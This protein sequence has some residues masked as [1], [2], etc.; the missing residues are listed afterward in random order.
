MDLKI[1]QIFLLS[2]V[3]IAST[4]FSIEAYSQ[5]KP[6]VD[7]FTYLKSG[8][9]KSIVLGQK[10]N[11]NYAL[12][13]LGYESDSLLFM[14]MKVVQAHEFKVKENKPLLLKFENDSITSIPAEKQVD[15]IRHKILIFD[16]QYGDI[17]YKMDMK[18][19]ELMAVQ[20]LTHMRVVTDSVPITI[21]VSEE[22]AEKM[23]YQ[24]RALLEQMQ[25]LGFY[26][27]NFEIQNLEP[28]IVELESK[29]K[30]LIKKG[31]SMGSAGKQYKK[32]GK[33]L[34]KESKRKGKEKKRELKKQKKA[35]K[36]ALKAAEKAAKMAKKENKNL[37]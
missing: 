9:T 26:K 36:K 27:P 7:P 21:V 15:A 2:F 5:V 12:T 32:E 25:L 3:A 30:V 33:A 22:K 14:N 35:E 20:N 37:F 34:I 28:T 8:K 4:L 24:A 1:K 18:L 23:K 6:Y 11:S 19:L 13:T 31:K 17:K 16:M 10:S 29:G